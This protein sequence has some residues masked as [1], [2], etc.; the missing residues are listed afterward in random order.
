MEIEKID[1]LSRKEYLELRYAGIWDFGNEDWWVKVPKNLEHLY[2]VRYDTGGCTNQFA[3]SFKEKGVRPIIVSND[4]SRFS[5]GDKIK[6]ANYY[7]TIITDNTMLCDGV[8]GHHH[9]EGW[10]NG[11]NNTELK[12]FIE[13]W[14]AAHKDDPAYL[15]RTREELT[16]I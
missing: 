1:L 13:S 9:Y 12:G 3:Y 5:V 7:W 16:E 4:L 11:F 2:Y 6:F 14:L 10:R 8:I 15:V